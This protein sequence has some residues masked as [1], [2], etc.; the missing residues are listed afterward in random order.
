M[1]EVLIIDTYRDLMEQE[2]LPEQEK[3][4]IEQWNPVLDDLDR[5]EDCNNRRYKEKRDMLDMT[6]CECQNEK[7][8]YLSSEIK[9][10][11]SDTDE[12]WL[13]WIFSRSS[14]DLY[15]LTGNIELAKSLQTLTAMQRK[16]VFLFYIH[17]FSVKDIA[18]LLG[19]SERNIRK[20]R[21]RAREH[22]KISC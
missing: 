19:S 16:V 6:L 20:L 18:A 9:L 21:A 5:E 22:M 13:E 7:G 1:R 2:R 3:V 8:G 14:A 11:L 17:G 15:Q 12:N 4:V 10:K